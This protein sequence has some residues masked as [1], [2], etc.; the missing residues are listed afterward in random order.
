MFLLK[1]KVTFMCLNFSYC[2]LNYA[3]NKKQNG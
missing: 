1:H 3:V 2:D